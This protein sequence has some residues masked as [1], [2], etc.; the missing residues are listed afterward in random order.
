MKAAIPVTSSVHEPTGTLVLVISSSR[1]RRG[2]REFGTT[3]C[4]CGLVSID[5]CEV[6]PSGGED[7]LQG[8]EEP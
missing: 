2:V 7:D 3:S 1:W 6:A 8:H 5:E 4:R